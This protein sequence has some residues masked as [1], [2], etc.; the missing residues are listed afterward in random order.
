MAVLEPPHLEPSHVTG[1]RAI[2]VAHRPAGR[3]AELQRQDGVADGVSERQGLPADGDDLLMVALC[4]Q[5]SDRHVA[6]LGA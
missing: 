2:A 3:L 5:G 6:L 4:E 1:D